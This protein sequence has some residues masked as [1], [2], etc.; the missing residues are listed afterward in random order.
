[1]TDPAARVARLADGFLVTQLLHVAVA[2][3][4]PDVLADGPASAEE[5]AAAVHADPAPCTGCS[6][7]SPPSSC[8]TSFPTAASA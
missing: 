4:V 7:G 5:L 1:M 2:L 3:G 8:S 6:A